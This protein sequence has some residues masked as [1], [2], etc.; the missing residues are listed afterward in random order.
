MSEVRAQARVNVVA[1]E[2]N[3][4]R[5]RSELRDGVCAVRRW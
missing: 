3:C 1:I 4:A 5:L 2:R